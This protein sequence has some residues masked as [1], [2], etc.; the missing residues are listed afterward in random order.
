[1]SVQLLHFAVLD[2]AG[3]MNNSAFVFINFGAMMNS[4]K[5]ISG[6]NLLE[7]S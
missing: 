6:H 7:L 5:T 1:M 2:E 4:V 3:H